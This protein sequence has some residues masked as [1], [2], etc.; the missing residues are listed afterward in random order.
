M[1]LVGCCNYCKQSMTIDERKFPLVNPE[2]Q[3]AIDMAV[4]SICDCPE[5]KSDRRREEQAQRIEGFL[6]DQVPV[7]LKGLFESAI[8][9]VRTFESPAV[10]IEDADGWKYKIRVDKEGY[11]CIDRKKSLSKKNKF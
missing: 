1:A 5:A 2:D 7:G 6:R 9:C 11:L 10:V 3:E 8:G 4:T